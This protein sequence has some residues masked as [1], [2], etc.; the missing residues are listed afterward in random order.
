MPHC[1]GVCS[2]TVSMP[3]CVDPSAADTCSGTQVGIIRAVEVDIQNEM[4]QQ[5]ASLRE[6]SKNLKH[7][8]RKADELAKQVAERDGETALTWPVY[9]DLVGWRAAW[10]RT[11][12]PSSLRNRRAS[13]GALLLLNCSPA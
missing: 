3:K 10:R 9:W 6:E 13:C 1:L 5:K 12:R 4:D 11:W 2:N 8:A 7:W